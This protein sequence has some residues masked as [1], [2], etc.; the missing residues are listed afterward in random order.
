MEQ[1]F[2]VAVACN[3]ASEFSRGEIEAKLIAE[4]E[5]DSG[6]V[7]SVGIFSHHSRKVVSISFVS[8]SCFVAISQP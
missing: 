2:R 1:G 4:A 8:T 3:H 7:L 5:A 6:E